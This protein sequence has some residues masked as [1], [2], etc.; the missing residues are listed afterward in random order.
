MIRP[1]NLAPFLFP[2]IVTGAV[3]GLAGRWDVWNVW[4]YVGM[5][6]GLFFFVILVVYRNNPDLLREQMKPSGPELQGRV[7]LS[8]VFN[9]MLILHLSIAGLDQRFHWSDGVPLP[10][11]VAGLLIC[12]VGLGVYVWSMSVNPFFSFVARI[13]ADRGQRV[14]SAGPYALVRHPGYAGIILFIVASGVALNSL[15]AIIPALIAVTS[16]RR[17]TVIED[18]MLRGGLA[19]YA[20]YAT[21]V[22]SRLIPGLW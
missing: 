16:L 9:V 11:V 1:L 7:Q 21:K 8:I 20:E 17:A 4:A 12:A 2:V 14:I 15:L 6:V 19:G 18:R 13:Q 5:L 22:R 10:A 3:F